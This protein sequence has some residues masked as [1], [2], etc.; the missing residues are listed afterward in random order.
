MARR[1]SRALATSAESSPISHTF[2]LHLLPST[3]LDT[4]PRLIRNELPLTESPATPQTAIHEMIP[5]AHTAGQ[6]DDIAS[7]INT[8]ETSA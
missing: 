4:I 7:P 1:S 6:S 8:A 2:R 5:E 3:T